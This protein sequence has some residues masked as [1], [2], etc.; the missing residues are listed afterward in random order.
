MQPFVPLEKCFTKKLKILKCVKLLRVRLAESKFTA[1]HYYLTIEL[2]M[3]NAIASRVVINALPDTKVSFNDMVVK[4]CAMALKKHPQVNSQWTE[5]A[6]IINHHVNIGV[7]VA[8]ED[9]L[10]V[11]VL[12]I[13]RPNE[14]NSNW[15]F[16][17]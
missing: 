4:A 8:V 10:L 1:P 11:P 6:I 17:C 13:Y 14:F 16:K 9:G 12:T 5:D 15:S 2:D 7:A 3:D